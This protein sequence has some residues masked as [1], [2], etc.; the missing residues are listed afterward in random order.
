MERLL[1][2]YTELKANALAMTQAENYDTD[3]VYKLCITMQEIQ[4]IAYTLYG[5][6][7]KG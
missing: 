7:L 4:S 2:A 1:Q 6:H 3:E 5:Q